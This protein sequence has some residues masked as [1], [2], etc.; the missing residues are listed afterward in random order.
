[1]G[2]RDPLVA[3]G[4]GRHG[5]ALRGKAAIPLAQKVAHTFKE[6]HACGKGFE[7]AS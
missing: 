3:L 6:P 1:M 5:R 4:S 7:C 2:D